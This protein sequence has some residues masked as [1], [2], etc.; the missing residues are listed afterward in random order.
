[1]GKKE[2]K[3]LEKW[4]EALKTWW[5]VRGGSILSDR[6]DKKKRTED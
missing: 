2:G 6:K 1:M 4:R 3:M 5:E